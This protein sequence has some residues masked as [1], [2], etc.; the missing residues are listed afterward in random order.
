MAVIVS[1][2]EIRR[3]RKMAEEVSAANFTV[4]QRLGYRPTPT[5]F[6]EAV[7]G[8][9]LDPWQRH[10]LTDA[11]ETSRIAIAACRQSGKSTVTAL[12][13]AWC[14]I[15][16]PGFQCL[17]ASRSLRQASHYI[18]SVR[19]AVL[20]MIPREA[21]IQLNRLSMELPNGSMIISIPCAQPDAGRGFSPNLVLLDEAAFAPEPLFRAISPSLA[22]TGGALHMISSPNGR[23][24]YFFDAFEGSA[25]D[26]YAT[27]RIKW[28]SCPRISPEFIEA[29]KIALG[30]LY[31]RQE[32]DAEFVSPLG[33]FF[34]FN[35]LSM[36]EQG[37]DAPVEDMELLDM[38]KWLKV[39][40]PMP[41]PSTGDMQL[42]FDRAD[43]VRRLLAG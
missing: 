23:Q 32:Y 8:N 4:E 6:G 40:D 35:A 21:M 16:I 9:L 1:L 27:Q 7:I 28:T 20:A 13:V 14:L 19:N 5:Q 39:N 25:K 37:E 10:Y 11:M 34:G 2:N 26:V 29:E 12:F 42:A 38:E 18:S 15:F 33:A 36:F 22:A 41:A 3:L 43:R 30:D 17:V 31:F 24:G